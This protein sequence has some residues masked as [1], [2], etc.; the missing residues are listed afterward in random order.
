LLTEDQGIAYCVVELK[1][2]LEVVMLKKYLE[3]KMVG[4]VHG[5]KHIWFIPLDIESKVFLVG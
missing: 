2:Y 4:K 1:K 3:G 5:Q